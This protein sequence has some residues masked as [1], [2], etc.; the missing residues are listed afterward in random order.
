MNGYME[1]AKQNEYLGF[2]V[3]N[4]VIN[5]VLGFICI[6]LQTKLLQ[7]YPTLSTKEFVT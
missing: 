7:S 6:A 4:P 1:G 2:R 3:I 5:A